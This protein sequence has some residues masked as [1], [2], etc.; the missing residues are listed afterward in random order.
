[1][2]NSSAR[3]ITALEATALYA[4]MHFQCALSRASRLHQRH[5]EHCTLVIQQTFAT[6]RPEQQR[7]SCSCCIC[8][9]TLLLLGLNVSC[10]HMVFAD[11]QYRPLHKSTLLLC[12]CTGIRSQ[13]RM[14]TVPLH[15]NSQGI[16]CRTSAKRM[17]AMEHDI[18]QP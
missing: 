8:G 10:T 5:T 16:L 13:G 17:D 3:T 7:S 18:P 15:V 14:L 9:C 12:T 11:R 1:M 6:A 2:I 4:D